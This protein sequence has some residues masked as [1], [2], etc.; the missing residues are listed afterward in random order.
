MKALPALIIIASLL[1]SVGF[2]L[3]ITSSASKAVRTPMASTLRQDLELAGTTANFGDSA[4][5]QALYEQAVMRYPDSAEAWAALGEFQRFYVH[6]KEAATISFRNA[7]A[8]HDKDAN[9]DAFAWRGLGELAAKAHQDALAMEYFTCSI[10]AHDLA[11]THSS[12]CHL[13]GRQRRFK[14]ASEHARRA[15]ELNNGDPVARLLYA[16][17]LHRAGEVARGLH[18]YHA[19]ILAGGIHAGES[20]EKVHCCVF[21]NAAGYLA[22]SDDYEGALRMLRRFFETPNHRHLSRDEIESD[23]DFEVLKS[24]PAFNALLD[25][26][27][28]KD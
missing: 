11:D 9:A 3:I 21:Y 5:A 17:Q 4:E 22:V 14:E 25:Q 12:L 15:V 10:E 13:Y 8:A 26:H 1:V 27:F 24:L 20:T 23:A 7:L 18:E 28:P 6:N 16:A 2:A 19:G